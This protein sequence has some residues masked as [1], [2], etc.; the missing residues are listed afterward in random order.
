MLGA[1]AAVVEEHYNLGN[2]QLAAAKFH[3]ALRREREDT[4]GLGSRLLAARE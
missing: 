4:K 1:S 2:L 3:D